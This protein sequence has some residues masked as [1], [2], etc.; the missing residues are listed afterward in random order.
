MGNVQTPANV[1]FFVGNWSPCQSLSFNSFVVSLSPFESVGSNED[2]IIYEDNII[3]TTIAI[4]YR[5]E[6]HKLLKK[7]L[8]FYN[9]YWCFLRLCLVPYDHR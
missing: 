8:K 7:N 4:I 2:N 6:D 5:K 9:R 1:H 3:N